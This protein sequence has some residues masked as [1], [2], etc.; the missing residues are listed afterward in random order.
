MLPRLGAELLDVGGHGVGLQ[1]RVV[2]ELRHLRRRQGRRYGRR[3]GAA[4]AEHL[5]H[6]RGDPLDVLRGQVRHPLLLLHVADHRDP[7][8]VPLGRARRR[9]EDVDDPLRRLRVDVS[10]PEGEE[11]R[12]V[13]LAGVLRERL[14]VAR[15]REDAGHLVRGHR[16][17][18]PGPVDDDSEVRLPLGHAE[19]GRP[20]E[21]RVVDRVLPVRP[22]VGDVVPPGPQVLL[23]PLLEVEAAVVGGEGDPKRRHGPVILSARDRHE[24][25]RPDHA[26]ARA[27]GNDAPPGTGPGG[28]RTTDRRS[29]LTWRPGP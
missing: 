14:G 5:L 12:V 18:D 3:G 23:Q 17:A 4:L 21:D 7:L 19:R 28:A 24:R 15:G 27:A 20:G 2:D 10:R 22:E 13:V 29:G 25:S 6:L 26:R 11:A 9:Q 16:G 1:E 8:Q